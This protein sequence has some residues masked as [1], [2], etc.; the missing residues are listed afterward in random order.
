MSFVGLLRRTLADSVD[1]PALILTFLIVF[2]VNFVVA[3]PMV[4]VMVSTFT[5]LQATNSVLKSLYTFTTQILQPLPF[6]SLLIT[7]VLYLYLIGFILARLWQKRTGDVINPFR[8][9]F[10]R[11]IHILVGYLF[12]LSVPL[13]FFLVYAFLQ[14]SVYN[15]VAF[16][17]FVLITILWVPLTFPVLT[18]LVVERVRGRD[19]VYEGLL[20]GKHYWWKILLVMIVITFVLY[21]LYWSVFLFPISWYP[22]VAALIYSW[23]TVATLALSVES[24]YGFKSG[25]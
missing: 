16:W 25:E 24:Y 22:Y 1:L 8:R 13:L 21:L 14:A 19:M 9:G 15:A 12:V 23:L 5:T 18:P 11:M 20:A 7:I 4:D 17:T 6:L 10:Y 3:P 2:T